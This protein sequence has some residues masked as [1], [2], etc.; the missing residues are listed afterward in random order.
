MKPAAVL[1]D[2][3][4]TTTPLAFVHDVLFPYARARLPAFC[5]QHAN[6][7]VLDAVKTEAAG[8]DPLR[9]LLGWMAA[10]AKIAALKTIQGMIWAEG[11]AAG[12]LAAVL[13]PDVAPALRR[14][15][16]AGLR[17]NVYS[18][19][20]Q[21]AQRL[22][23]A[24]SGEGDLTGLFEGFFD[25]DAGPK[26]AAASY[27]GIAAALGLPAGSLLFLSDVEAELDAAGEAGLSTCQ[28]V[29]P[30]DRT[31]AGAR[32]AVAG[33]FKEVAARFSLG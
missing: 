19:G 3:E 27:R 16:R 6:D 30:V 22:L 1:T 11:Y 12:E 28:L 31:V 4:G 24:H 10:D 33:D 29:R 32:H 21:A 17:L 25:T 9:A 13:Y 26:R 5:V 8:A 2:I 20:S 18:S 15:H 23:F 14:W 7:P